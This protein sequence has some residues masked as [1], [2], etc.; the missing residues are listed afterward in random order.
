LQNRLSESFHAKENVLKDLEAENTSL[1]EEL[2]HV[3]DQL[4][5]R[6][7]LYAAQERRFIDNSR[8]YTSQFSE[9]TSELSDLR[10]RSSSANIHLMTCSSDI[11]Q[12]NYLYLGFNSWSTSSK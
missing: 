1:K 10:A 3:S 9:R 5:Q 7:V 8:M 12:S 11:N 6:A 4:A 2:G